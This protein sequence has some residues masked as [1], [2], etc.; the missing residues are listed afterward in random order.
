MIKTFKNNRTGKNIHNWEDYYSDS[1]V[2][3]PSEQMKEIIEIA[4]KIRKSK[5]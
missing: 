1:Y 3:R 5:V 2:Y 4:E